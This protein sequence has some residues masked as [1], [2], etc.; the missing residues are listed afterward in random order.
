MT[1]RK[2]IALRRIG[3]PAVVIMSL[4]LAGCGGG[5][6]GIG[7]STGGLPSPD[8]LAPKQPASDFVDDEFLYN[9]G[10]NMIGAQHAYAEGAYGSG[11][12]VAV[13]DSGIDT[14]HIDL[15][16]NIS[17]LSKDIVMPGEPL[18]DEIGH[19]TMTAGIIGAERNDFILHGVAFDSTILA[20]RADARNPDGTSAGFFYVS[21]IANAINYVA[22]KAHVVNIGLGVA[23]TTGSDS[24]GADFE[25]ALIDAMAEN[26]IIVTPTGNETAAEPVLPAAYAGDTTVNASGQ[27]VAVAGAN[28]AG[29][30]LLAES[31]HCGSAMQY[32]LVAPA[33]GIWSTFPGDYVNFPDTYWYAQGDGTSF[34]AAHVSGAAALMIQLWPTL[35]P[36][37]IVDIL[38]SSATDLGDPGIDPIYGHGLLNIEAA[39]APAGSLEV[40]LGDTPAGP[41]IALEGT[42]LAL[43]PAFGDA[44]SK[45]KLLGEAFALDDYDRNYAADLNAH[46]I[47]GQRDFSLRALSKLD[48]VE[49]VDTLLPNG[50]RIALGVTDDGQSMRATEWP[51]VAADSEPRELRGMSLSID[52]R[53]GTQYRLGYD[54]TPEQ[55]LPSLAASEPASLF[56][57][58]GDLLGPHYGLVGTG[59]AFSAN[60]SL[61]IGNRLTA[62]FV[63]DSGGDND[64]PG[65]A[66]IAEVSFQ[67]TFLKSGIIS[68]SLSAVD[69]SNSFLGSD[70]EAGFGVRGTGS[71]F[72]SVS[73]IIPVGAGLELIGNYTLGEADVVAGRN[74]VLSNWS[75]LSADAYGVGIVRRGVFGGDDRVGLLAG[76]PM[77]VS[78]GSTT[79]ALPVG[80]RPDKSVEQDS[81]RVSLAPSGREFDLQLAYSAEFGS[82]S[83][84][85]TWLMVQMEPGHVATAAPAYGFG[86]RFSTEF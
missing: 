82:R 4:V 35:A 85:S 40:P 30:D 33:E 66:R 2:L 57:M 16:D 26:A 73:G 43:N 71:Y 83:E 34:A 20:V 21:D 51:G 60:H 77:R 13:I 10:L 28:S 64:R 25:Q 59:L 29:D 17:P 65:S 79:L 37:E 44:L 62:G 3:Q 41:K 9:Y 7:T 69:E 48:D 55:Q 75:R 12:V 22:G 74:S 1:D 38:L 68:A 67:H 15:K 11:V 5:G 45:S 46:V 47:P 39:L 76:Q 61:G 70:A 36:S 32:C 19:G 52:G 24:L 50:M 27:M 81:E 72:Y 42:Y 54:T 18:A 14:Q 63:D 86:L 78:S 8:P 56:W 84:M 23:G 49:S 31:N 80:Y 6:G 58:P 53:N